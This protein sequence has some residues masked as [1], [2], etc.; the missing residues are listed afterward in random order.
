MNK[1][2]SGEFL[3]SKKAEK[4]LFGQD[5]YSELGGY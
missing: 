2:K 5:T 4:C 1:E 3:K